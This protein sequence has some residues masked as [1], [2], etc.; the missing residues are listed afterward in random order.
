MFRGSGPT[1]PRAAALL[2]LAL[3]S[4]G[5]SAGPEARGVSLRRAGW[6]EAG[7]TCGGPG[8]ASGAQVYL[9]DEAGRRVP[10]AL[11]P[12]ALGS[13]SLPEL[14]G[15]RVEVRA[16]S[17]PAAAGAALRVQSLRPLESPGLM[18]ATAPRVKPYVTLLVRFSDTRSVTPFPP[19]TVETLFGPQPGGLEHFYDELSYGGHSFAGSRVVGWL[20][21]PHPKS[22]YVRGGSLDQMRLLADAVTAADRLVRFPDFYGINI[23]INTAAFTDYAGFGGIF[24]VTADGQSRSYGV[25][26]ER[27]LDQDLHLDQGTWAHEIGHSLGWPHSSGPYR[28]TYDSRWDLM[29][30]SYGNWTPPFG[31]T[32]RGTIGWHKTLAGWV[33]AARRYLAARGTEKTLRLER[34]AQPSAEGYLYAQVPLPGGREFYTVEARQKAGYDDT[35]P[36]DGV[37]IHRVDPRLDDRNAQ[38]ADATRNNDPNDDGAMW[39]PGETFKDT[40]AGVEV[41]VLEAL[42]SGFTVRIRSGRAGAGQADLSGAW[43]GVKVRRLKKGRKVTYQVRGTAVVRNTGDGAAGPTRLRFFLS[44]DAAL[45]PQDPPVTVTVNSRAVPLEVPMDP[46]AAGASGRAPVSIKV[47]KSAYAAWKGRY[48]LGAADATGVVSEPDEAN[49]V[50]ASPRLP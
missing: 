14:A 18:A 15:R 6:L 47:R 8:A 38:V 45:D 9:A 17:G 34:L 1:L 3:L 24:R 21:L 48:L 16:E 44:E 43:E 36:G 11:A 27:P 31:Y 41:E 28:E 26:W 10:L 39:L 29:S 13:L 49:N 23:C 32:G 35:V 37:V 2:G 46:V 50:F 40:A 4:V 19:A 20:D 7:W 5:L 12:D 25:T 42:E 33:P 30:V 22:T